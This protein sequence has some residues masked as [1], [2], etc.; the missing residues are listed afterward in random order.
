M[1]KRTRTRKAASADKIRARIQLE[2]RDI[3]ELKNY[4]LT[5]LVGNI[6]K[7][8]SGKR[9]FHK[10]ESGCFVWDGW[11]DKE[12]YGN[13]SV[14]GKT[15][16]VHRLVYARCVGELHA[17]EVVR[18]SCDNPSCI[19][20][21]HLLKGTQVDNIEDKVRRNRQA[22]HSTH[23]GAVLTCR[24]VA[25]IKK[26]LAEGYRNQS[27]LARKHKVSQSTIWCIANGITWRSQ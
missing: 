15:T 22:R 16:R 17:E 8:D 11:K 4:D 6:F 25:N 10:N 12:G 5:V 14:E 2:Y 23:P 21:L 27:A 7:R 9:V 1:Q 20:P 19:N 24:E 3:S 18:H 13:V 26:E